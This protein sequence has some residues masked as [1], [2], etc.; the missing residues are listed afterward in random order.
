MPNKQSYVFLLFV[1]KSLFKASTYLSFP[2]SARI[3]GFGVHCVYLPNNVL[4][5]GV[6]RLRYQIRCINQAIFF[7]PAGRAFISRHIYTE[8]YQIG[9]LVAFQVFMKCKAA[10][11][12]FLESLDIVL[13]FFERHVQCRLGDFEELLKLL[14]RF[15]FLGRFF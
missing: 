8:N 2:F 11:K 12:S 7:L 5:E 1:L 15:F 3:Y 10:L 14:L 6:G 13:L 9:P 4:I